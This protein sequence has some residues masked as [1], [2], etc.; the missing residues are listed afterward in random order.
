MFSSC[1][2]AAAAAPVHAPSPL[3]PFPRLHDPPLQYS[4]PLLPN[5]VPAWVVPLLSLSTPFV[6]ILGFHLAGRLPRLAAHHGVVQGWAAVVITGL[7]TNLIKLNVSG[8]GP[9]MYDSPLCAPAIRGA[10]SC[11]LDTT[12]AHHGLGLVPVRNPSL[13]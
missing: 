2:A 7:I 4:Y 1:A 12:H 6:I 10:V 13:L 5:H 8:E 3:S 11:R 9:V